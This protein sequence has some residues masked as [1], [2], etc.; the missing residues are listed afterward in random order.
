M[1][2]ASKRIGLI[3]FLIVMS[4]LLYSG[5]WHYLARSA[6]KLLDEYTGT[7]VNEGLQTTYRQINVLGYPYRL[8]ISLDDIEVH[9]TTNLN[10]FALAIPNFRMTAHPWNLQHWVGVSGIPSQIMIELI[11]GALAVEVG[12][13]RA[14]LVVGKQR[15]PERF[16][17]QMNDLVFQSVSGP[18]F[19]VLDQLQ[20]HLRDPK[21]PVLSRDI[22]ILAHNLTLNNIGV[23]QQAI[24]VD[25]FI[26]EAKLSGPTLEGWNIVSLN[27]WRASSGLLEIQNLQVSAGSLGVVFSGAISLDALLRPVGAGTVVIDGYR[28]VLANLYSGGLINNVARVAATL[29]LDLLSTTSEETGQRSVEAPISMQDG[30]LSLGPV[31]LMEISPIIA[32]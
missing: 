31:P 1:S 13:G 18:A 14:S 27:G 22:G 11:Q 20:V 21:D 2:S 16:S 8:E 5:Y 10:K 32:P 25:G 23:A 29:T 17:L 28:E 3:V 7:W 19:G 15:R 30:V 26:M 6:P 4:L 9:L 12:R 24:N